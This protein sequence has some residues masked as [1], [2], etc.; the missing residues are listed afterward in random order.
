L[1]L[2]HPKLTRNK[3][4]TNSFRYTSEVGAGLLFD[5]VLAMANH[6]CD[7]NAEIECGGRTVQLVA[8]REIQEG[9]EVFIS[10]IDE[11]DPVDVRREQLKSRYFFDCNCERCVR[12]KK[13]GGDDPA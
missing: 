12:Q 4:K 7:P 10:Y 5:P 8:L 11:D 2:E 9:E 13:D 6:S 1:A 3:M